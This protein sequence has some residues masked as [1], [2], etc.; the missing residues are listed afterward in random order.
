MGRDKRIKALRTLHSYMYIV[1]LTGKKYPINYRK[2]FIV[3]TC[4]TETWFRGQCYVGVGGASGYVYMPLKR[5]SKNCY[6]SGD[7]VIRE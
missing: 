1:T 6:Y 4:N 3:W 2:P 5:K 7:L